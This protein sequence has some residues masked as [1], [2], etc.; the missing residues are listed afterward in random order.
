MKVDVNFSTAVKK[1]DKNEED[2]E[3][4]MSNFV[5]GRNPSRFDP[6]RVHKLEEEELSD[7]TMIQDCP[8]SKLKMFAMN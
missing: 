1:E 7:K 8:W 4:D 6:E 2:K 5:L 3:D